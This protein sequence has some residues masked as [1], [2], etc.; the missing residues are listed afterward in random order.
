MDYNPIQPTADAIPTV[1]ARFRD[2]PTSPVVVSEQLSD[3]HSLG[4]DFCASASPAVYVY[5]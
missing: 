1:H 2:S 4:R 5:L 3:T